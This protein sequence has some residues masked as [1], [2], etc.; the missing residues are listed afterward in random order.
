MK[1]FDRDASNRAES[2]EYE[3]LAPSDGANTIRILTVRFVIATTTLETEAP[4][5]SPA[6]ALS[7]CLLFSRSGF[8]LRHVLTTERWC[9]FCVPFPARIGRVGRR[10]NLTAAPVA[11]NLRPVFPG[12]FWET[13]ADLGFR[14]RVRRLQQCTPAAPR[15]HAVADVTSGFRR[16][17]HSLPVAGPAARSGA[18]PSADSTKRPCN[19]SPAVTCCSADA[20]VPFTL[21]APWA[22]DRRASPLEGRALSPPTG[23]RGRRPRR[24]RHQP[25]AARSAPRPPRPPAPRRAP[26][27]ASRRTAPRWRGRP[28]WRPPRRAP[29]A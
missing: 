11:V 20:F 1:P 26:R 9:R 18:C 16:R 3:A 10:D 14:P 24:A 2:P 28:P 5:R 27:G 17:C 22:M 8:R 19:T 6:L 23:P 15:W 21:T 13:A 7:S 25:G 12:D 4:R 29:T